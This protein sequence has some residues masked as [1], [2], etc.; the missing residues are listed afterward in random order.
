MQLGK[1]PRSALQLIDRLNL[2]STIFTDTTTQ[3]TIPSTDNWSIVYDC[4]EALKSNQTPKSIYQS[5]VRSDDAKY[6]GWILAALTPWVTVPEP[7][8]VKKGKLPPPLATIVAR[9]GIKADNKVC[10]I[11]TGAFRDYEQITQLKNDIKRKEPYVNERDTIGMTIRRWDGQGGHWRMQALF[12]IL[13]GALKKNDRQ[14]NPQL[15][16][17]CSVLTQF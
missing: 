13:A 1:D 2:Y 15:I 3:L 11:V 7:A 16:L 4:L 8:P 10:N 17:R 6:W 9:E 12:A 5:L 14:G